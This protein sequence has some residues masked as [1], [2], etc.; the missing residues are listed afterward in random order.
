MRA[1]RKLKAELDVELDFVFIHGWGMDGQIFNRLSRS[2]KAEAPKTIELGFIKGGKTNWNYPARP[3]IY[4]T[5]SLGTLWL[6][7]EWRLRGVPSLGALISLNGFSCFTEFTDPRQLKL[8]QRGLAKNPA[9]Q[10]SDFWRRAGGGFHRDAGGLNAER[11]SEG[12]TWLA[13]WDETKT[14]ASLKCPVLALGSAMDAIVPVEN[15]KA[16]WQDHNTAIHETASHMLPLE[17]PE[18]CRDE[19]LK[20]LKTSE[21]V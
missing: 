7:R 9:A 8:M 13:E 5:H 11:L 18:W 17:A 1:P 10:M 19:I 14:L 3:A 21:L 2:L 20:F 12:L 4:I 15:F 16:T 6:L